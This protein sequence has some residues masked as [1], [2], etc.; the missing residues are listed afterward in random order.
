MRICDT[1]GKPIT[2]G[3]MQDGDGFFHTHEGPCFFEYM[4]KTYGKHCWMKLGAKALV[5]DGGY[6]LVTDDENRS[7]YDDPNIFYTEYEDEE[8]EE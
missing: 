3:C 7:G 8:E 6:Y 4:D 5:Y 2:F 1:C